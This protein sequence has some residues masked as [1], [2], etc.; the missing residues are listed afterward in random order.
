MAWIRDT[1]SG[2]E[3]NIL[4]YTKNV[5]VYK[6]TVYKYCMYNIVH[7]F[8]VRHTD[9]ALNPLRMTT[10]KPLKFINNVEGCL[11]D[12]CIYRI[13]S[14]ML[15]LLFSLTNPLLNNYYIWLYRSYG[16]K[17]GFFS[18]AVQMINQWN[19]WPWSHSRNYRETTST[20][21]DIIQFILLCWSFLIVI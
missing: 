21:G 2:L 10:Y 14:V 17:R 20:H 15:S 13:L 8:L 6:Y 3:N 5:C 1:S 19:N 7:F 12:F 9:P 18:Y 11:W 16:K 4:I